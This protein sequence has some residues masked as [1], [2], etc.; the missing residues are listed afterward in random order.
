VLCL[1]LPA[2]IGSMPRQCQ[3][4]SEAGADALGMGE[5]Q[6]MI[7]W[8][9]RV[10][11]GCDRG[12]NSTNGR[13]ARD[14][15]HDSAC[16]L[17]KTRRPGSHPFHLSS[18]DL[19]LHG[20]SQSIISRQPTDGSTQSGHQPQVPSGSPEVSA[21]PNS[22][23]PG[24]DCSRDPPFFI[25]RINLIRGSGHLGSQGVW[26]VSGSIIRNGSTPPSPGLAGSTPQ[27]S[28]TSRVSAI[29]L[30]HWQQW[31]VYLMP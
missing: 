13:S 20:F 31:Q 29:P 4:A 27:I 30:P 11:W 6:R 16:S 1:T 28:I 15:P 18:T 24:G 23:R 5:V 2:R 8:G 7:Q 26:W 12:L 19:P 21:S 3:I 17:V 10:L 14:W 9:C 25:V 22:T